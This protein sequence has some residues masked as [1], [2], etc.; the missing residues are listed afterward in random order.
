MAGGS[1]LVAHA[2]L[3]DTPASEHLDHELRWWASIMGPVRDLQV[4]QDRL[5]ALVADLDEELV[6]GPVRTRIDVELGRDRLQHWSAVV[7]ALAGERHRAM[8]GHLGRWQVA[9]PW[10]AK[11][12]RA[13]STLDGMVLDA[14][15][16]VATRLA[17]ARRSGEVEDMHRA[18]KAAKRARYAAEVVSPVRGKAALRTVDR[19]R[20]LQDLLGELQDS[21]V[22]AQLLRRLADTADKAPGESSFTFGLLHEREQRRARETAGEAKRLAR[23]LFT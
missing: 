11:A 7:E 20:R 15:R 2:A 18:R 6:I 21:T 16:T 22:S 4:L 10:T 14:D 13:D 19:Y 5:D 23:R 12:T 3:F 1:R 9:P 8:V 17:R